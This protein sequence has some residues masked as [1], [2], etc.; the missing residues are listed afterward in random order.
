[1]MKKPIEIPVLDSMSEHIKKNM[2]MYWGKDDPATSDVLK[3]LTEQLITLNSEGIKSFE[4][5]GW[6]FIGADTDWIESGLAN[7]RTVID[8]FKKG[9]GFSEAGGLSLRSELFVYEF[10][11]DLVLWRKEEVTSLKGKSDQ[12]LESIFNECFLNGVAICFRGN[13]YARNIITR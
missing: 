1:M 11:E 7:S 4:K 8:L 10:A 5:N 9:S 2:R 12:F 13:V 3:A 6:N